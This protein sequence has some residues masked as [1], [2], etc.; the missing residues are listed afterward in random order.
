MSLPKAADSEGKP[1]AGVG[2][3]WVMGGLGQGVG[4][5]EAFL[6]KDGAG[7]MGEGQISAAPGCAGF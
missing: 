2:S 6:S 3:G 1:A 5:M 4:G 7:R